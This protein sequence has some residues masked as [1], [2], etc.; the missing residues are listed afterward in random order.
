VLRPNA[1]QNAIKRC[2]VFYEKF[3]SNPFS[4]VRTILQKHFNR[5][6]WLITTPEDGQQKGCFV[7]K[8]GTE[9]VFIKL[10]VPVAA[11]QRLSEIEVAPRVIASGTLDGTSYVV[12]EYITG[13]YPDWRWFANH[14][15]TLAAFIKRYH[16]DQPLASLLAA[17]T[18]TNYVE[19]VALDLATL[20]SQFTSRHSEELQAPTIVSAFEK[21]KAWSKQL[22]AVPLVPVHPDLNTKNILLT[23]D[24]L[25]MVDWDD[26]QLS[27]PMRDAGLL[28]WW[29]VAPHQWHEFFEAYGL[30]VNDG[31]IERIYWWAARTSLAI[32][33]WHVE[34]QYD[35]QAFL[36]DFLAAVNMESNPHAVFDAS[37]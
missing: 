1:L 26:M 23:S 14:L 35:S 21:L 12:Q 5:T 11:L 10:D 22:Q 29:Y 19:H 16:T 13:N 9:Q 34:H 32:A 27:D 33:L 6:D 7:A 24:S 31:L 15:P 17:N 36:M 3:M 37:K 28:L 4:N 30:E 2:G 8:H 25:L 18:P 20:E